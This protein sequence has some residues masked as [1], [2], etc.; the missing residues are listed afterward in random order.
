MQVENNDLWQH[1]EE[2]KAKKKRKRN[3]LS[4]ELVL[5]LKAIKELTAAREAAQKAK[6]QAK[7]TR[8]RLK[9][10]Y[11]VVVELAKEQVKARKAAWKRV[12]NVKELAKVHYREVGEVGKVA[13]KAQKDSLT[14][15]SIAR[16]KHTREA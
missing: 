6:E 12:A 14:A 16:R 10:D 8:K 3:V 15:A 1:I 5:T 7:L 9:K 2:R 13:K 4:T 11:Q